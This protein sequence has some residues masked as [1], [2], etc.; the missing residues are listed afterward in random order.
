M[1]ERYPYIRF[2]IDAGQVIAG[3]VAFVLL[4]GGTIR[5]C[6]HGVVGGFIGFLFAVLVAAV[7]Y[8]VV[9]VKIEALRVFLDIEQSTRQSLAASRQSTPPTQPGAPT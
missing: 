1:D 4:L 2:F 7:A 6:H 8:V 5:A 9:M 3:A